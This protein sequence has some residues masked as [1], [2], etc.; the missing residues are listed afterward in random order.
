MRLVSDAA[1]CCHAA[2]SFV[3]AALARFFL[4]CLANLRRKFAKHLSNLARR[5]LL[6]SGALLVKCAEPLGLYKY[7]LDRNDVDDQPTLTPAV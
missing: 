4:G 1:R 3:S 2:R 6:N 5:E 7:K